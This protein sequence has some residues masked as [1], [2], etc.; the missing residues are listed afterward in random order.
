VAFLCG[1]HGGGGWLRGGCS[2]RGGGAVAPLE[3]A[4][5]APALEEEESALG[6]L[7]GFRRPTVA[8]GGGRSLEDFPRERIMDM[9]RARFS[10][11]KK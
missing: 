6:R 8:V 2:L 1:S 10:H 7:R 3:R 4:S 11:Q 9:G 5:A